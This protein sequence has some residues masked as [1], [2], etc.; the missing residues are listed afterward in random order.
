MSEKS[1]TVTVLKIR[2]YLKNQQH[3]QKE[4]FM[5]IKVVIL[6]LISVLMTACGR[7]DYGKKQRGELNTVAVSE[8]IRV[9]NSED[10]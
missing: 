6:L 1:N 2:K 3:L 4:K 8:E 5:K 10:L 9:N 7:E